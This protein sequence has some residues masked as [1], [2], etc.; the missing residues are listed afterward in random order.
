[1]ALAVPG[2]HPKPRF[3]PNITVD[4]VRTMAQIGNL[5]DGFDPY[6][7]RLGDVETKVG[8]HNV[9]DVEGRVTG[10]E[11]RANGIDNRIDG[12]EG[13]VEELEGEEEA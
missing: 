12:I 11:G 3:D 8:A 7:S 9:G 6:E 13:R 10:L 5:L 4:G 1:M 2:I